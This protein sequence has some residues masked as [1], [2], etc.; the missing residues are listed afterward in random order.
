MFYGIIKIYKTDK[1]GGTYMFDIILVDDEA[2]ALKY[3]AELVDWN[4]YS[5]NLVKYFRSGVSALEFIKN[6]PPDLI[7]TD[8]KMPGVSG[9]D[10]ADYCHRNIPDTLVVFI[11]AY[12][13]FDYAKKALN[14]SVSDYILKP[15]TADE[16][17]QTLVKMREKLTGMKKPKMEVNYQKD[18]NGGDEIIA[19]SNEFLEGNYSKKI[20]VEDAANYVSLS[21]PYFCSYFKKK[22]GMTFMT[23]LNIYRINKAKELLKAPDTKASMVYIAVGF[24]SRS[25]FNSIFKKCTKK[26][27][28]QYQAEIWGEAR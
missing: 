16:V 27:P 9:L 6:T 18:E 13:D 26:T 20:T 8:I 10:I 21:A 11:S 17:I 12:R 1:T 24:K 4:E 15:I 23:A 7:I 25:H 19:M 5:F 2:F 22:T 14:F 28:A 3:L